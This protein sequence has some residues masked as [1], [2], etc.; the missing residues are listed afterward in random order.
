MVV[1]TILDTLRAG[2]Q[3]IINYINFCI[4]FIQNYGWHMLFGGI[5]LYYVY[6]QFIKGMLKS[7][8]LGYDS[9]K[10]KKDEAQ[11]AAKYHKDPDL[12]A[13]RLSAQQERA[14]KLQEKYDEEAKIHQAK[15]KEKE[16][17]KQQEVLRLLEQSG[18]AGHKLGE[19]SSKSFR[20]DYHPLMG[21]GTS[22]NY[23]PPKRT[24]CGGGGCG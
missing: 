3:E 1:D 24:K 14:Q 23:R 16:A 7:A 21:P 4:L 11:Y 9:Y 10:K 2:L 17:K 18:Q 5:I 8:F 12:F 19:G 15:L 6:K 20:P 13:A 22:S